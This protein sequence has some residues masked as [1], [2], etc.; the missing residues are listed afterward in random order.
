MFCLVTFWA[1]TSL[2]NWQGTAGLRLPC[3]LQGWVL[4]DTSRPW[5]GTA[6][7]HYLPGTSQVIS[8]HGSS[9]PLESCEAILQEGRQGLGL[10]LSGI[11]QLQS[12]L[13]SQCAWKLSQKA[14]P[15]RPGPGFGGANATSPGHPSLM[16]SEL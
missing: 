4:G 2:R 10:T 5:W 13:G 14:G 7:P 6:D 9:N 16:A 8:C 1:P 12:D 3:S 11:S 15:V